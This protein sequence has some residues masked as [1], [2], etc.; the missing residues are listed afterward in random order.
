MKKYGISREGRMGEENKSKRATP[1][2]I[3]IRQS[4][5][6]FFKFGLPSIIA[7]SQRNITVPHPVCS[8]RRLPDGLITQSVE[9]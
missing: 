8:C 3:N 1:D 9:Y 2:A 7:S 5:T 4:K 6:I